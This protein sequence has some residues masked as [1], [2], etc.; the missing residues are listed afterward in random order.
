MLV[1]SPTFLFA[2][3]G[4]LMCVGGLGVLAWLGVDRTLPDDATGVA[5]AMAAI[6]LVG[7]Q[8]IQLG[9]FARTYAVV[10]LGETDA[11][12]ESLWRRYRLEHGLLLSLLALAGGLAIVA[13]SYFNGVS[14]PRL[15]LLGLTLVALGVQGAFGAFFLSILGLSEHAVLRRRGASRGGG[16]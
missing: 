10:Y 5:M 3:P 8:V 4:G 13:Y 1:H 12:L 15:G 16:S 7:A 9:L 2:I 11:T 6:A 14:D